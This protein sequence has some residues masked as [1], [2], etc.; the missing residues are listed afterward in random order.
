MGVFV[1]FVQKEKKKKKK[2]VE[3]KSVENRGRASSWEAQSAQQSLWP[4]CPVGARPQVRAEN[5]GHKA[6]RLGTWALA[7]S[8]LPAHY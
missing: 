3:G 5:M 4:C 1:M 2:S 6:G 7:T 8:S